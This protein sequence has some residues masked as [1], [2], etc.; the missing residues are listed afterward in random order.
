MEGKGSFFI[1]LFIVAF[2]SLTLAVLAGYV[3]FVGGNSGTKPASEATHKETTAK[4]AETELLTESLVDKKYYN[5]KSTDAAKLSVLQVALKVT[6][7]KGKLAEEP[8][9]KILEP[10]IPR[11]KEE[12]STYFAGITIEEARNQKETKEKAKKELLAKFNEIVPP[13]EKTK[14][15]LVIEVVFEDWFAQ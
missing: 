4:I 11:M 5:L 10:Y 12:V 2:L 13:D 1:L 6:I 7:Y 9:K 8:A 15:K 3:F 14:R